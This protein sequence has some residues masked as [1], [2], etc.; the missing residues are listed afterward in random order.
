MLYNNYISSLLDNK[1][2]LFNK[3]N[4]WF[5]ITLTKHDYKIMVWLVREK[6]RNNKILLDLYKNFNYFFQKKCYNV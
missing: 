5:G 4:F 1:S 6:I 3:N 2:F